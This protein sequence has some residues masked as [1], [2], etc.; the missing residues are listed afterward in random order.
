MRVHPRRL[1]RRRNALP[2][3]TV[4]GAVI[5][6]LP[7]V[8]CGQTSRDNLGTGAV[9]GG[10]AGGSDSG[11]GG[12]GAAGVEC[13]GKH[14]TRLVPPPGGAFRWQH[15]AVSWRKDQVI[16]WGG[17]SI[18]PN[19]PLATGWRVFSDGSVLPLPEPGAPT[20]RL[21]HCCDVLGNR[22][23]V[24]GGETGSDSADDG[25]S[26]DLESAQWSAIPSPGSLF[27]SRI[28]ALSGSAGARWLLWGGLQGDVVADGALYDPSTEKWVSTSAAPAPSSI[29]VAALARGAPD[30]GPAV[31]G[32]F[33]NGTT[34]PGYGF[35][36]AAGDWW[37]MASSDAPTARGNASFTWSPAT[38][39]F[40]VWGGNINST[41]L[42]DGAKYA[43][44][45]AWKPMSGVNAPEPRDA[46]YAAMAGSKLV[47]WGGV[48]E[49]GHLASG[50]IYDVIGDEWQPLPLDECAPGP[51]S[52]ATFTAFGDGKHILLWG[53]IPEPQTATTTPVEQGWLLEL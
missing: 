42:G 33:V 40:I 48:G 46:P 12:A 41:P 6:L 4:V 23:L 43:L 16:I 10:G 53:G 1:D 27:P 7:V 22:L 34:L 11:S 14:W 13:K 45:G 36:P 32:G 25:A 21:H 31:F 5:G 9:A 52:E 39:E 44:N 50:G 37:K 38:E 49:E 47:I 26:L 2:S 24:F 17:G 35:D 18:D 19:Q 8:G 29:D 3:L 15:P 30:I 20:G 28:R 51:R